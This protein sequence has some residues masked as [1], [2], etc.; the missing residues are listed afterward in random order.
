MA[1]KVSS[2][3]ENIVRDWKN[4]DVSEFKRK[5]SL[6]NIANYEFQERYLQILDELA[7]KKRFQPRGRVSKW[8]SPGTKRKME[9]RDKWRQ[10]AVQSNQGEDW[11]MYRDLRN[12]VTRDLKTDRRMHKE[13]FFKYL[14]D[15]KDSRGLF[16]M[17]K[18]LA[19][20]K[21]GGTPEAFL[22][23]G[24]LTRNPRQMVEIQMTAFVDKV[25]KLSEK[26]PAPNGDPMRTLRNTRTRLEEWNNVPLLELQLV[27]R[28]EMLELLKQLGS[29]HAYGHDGMDG[30]SL[31]LVAESVANPVRH[32]VKIFLKKF[33][34]CT[35]LESRETNSPT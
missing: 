29:S 9:D 11:R 23:E 7:P 13:G 15:K 35:V 28:T 12:Q 4:F 24:R 3:M 2:S 17:V 8:V 31:S 22:V 26:L 32:I 10:E 27:G 14:I 21:T 19:G 34:I 1:G 33:L 18:N 6:V 5:M 20:W 16:R 25:K 30:A